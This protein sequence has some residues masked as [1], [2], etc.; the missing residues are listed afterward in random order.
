[1]KIEPNFDELNSTT[2][3]KSHYMYWIIVDVIKFINKPIGY[4]VWLP[5]IL[6][7]EAFQETELSYLQA[8]GI[9]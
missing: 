6:H 8:D 1:M 3:T 4:K 5:M 7:E 9:S 2:T